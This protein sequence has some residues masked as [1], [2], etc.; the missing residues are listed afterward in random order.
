MHGHLT[1]ALFSRYNSHASLAPANRMVNIFTHSSRLLNYTP[2]SNA[3]RIMKTINRNN[4][5]SEPV[6]VDS[7]TF[8]TYAVPTY[9]LERS[10]VI[11]SAHYSLTYMIQTVIQPP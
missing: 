10:A 6:R 5:S 9:I 3:N 7:R 1:R 2:Y 8:D 11:F 4:E